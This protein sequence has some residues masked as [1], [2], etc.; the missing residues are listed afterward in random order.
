M[1]KP[2]Q[3]WMI[4]GA[5]PILGNL[6][7]YIYI[8]SSTKGYLR[9]YI[10]RATYLYFL[11]YGCKSHQLVK[12]INIYIYI[13]MCI[14]IYTYYGGGST[15]IVPIC[16]G[17]KH[18]L[19]SYDLLGTANGSQ[20]AAKRSSSQKKRDSAGKRNPS[21]VMIITM[22]YGTPESLDHVLK[23]MVTWGY[24][25]TWLKNPPYI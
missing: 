21:Q 1:E 3:Q 16:W 20:A 15:P 5:T 22:T 23:P 24:H 8:L 13:H 7:I 17:N 14:Y 2:E 11:K 6:S 12:P 19:S 25:M 9:I 18:P 10:W 4:T